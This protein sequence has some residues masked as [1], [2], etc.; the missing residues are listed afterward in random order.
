MDKI[1]DLASKAKGSGGGSSESSTGSSGGSGGG[2]DKYIDKGA[3]LSNLD[4][5]CIRLTKE[6]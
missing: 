2:A 1:K 4:I 3:L 6:K 5:R